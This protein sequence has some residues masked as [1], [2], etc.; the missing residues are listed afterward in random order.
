MNKELAKFYINYCLNCEID[1][2]ELFYEKS[3]VTEA[4]LKE[5]KIEEASASIKNGLG[6]RLAYKDKISYGSTSNMDKNN[7][8]SIID[9]LKN[10]YNKKRI[11]DEVSLKE[12]NHEFDYKELSLKE[13][14]DLLYNINC[15]AKKIEPKIYK[16]N[17]VLS[18]KNQNVI[19]A[20]SKGKFVKDK[21]IY[22]LLLIEIIMK[23]GKSM[24]T[25]SKRFGQ[26]SNCEFLKNIDLEKELKQLINTAKAKLN[27]VTMKGGVMPAVIGPGF[28]AVIFHE[29]VGHALEATSVGIKTSVLTGKYNKLIASDK[30]TLVDDGT[31]ENLWGTTYY[32]D[33]GNKTKRNVL[34]DSGKLTSYLIDELN[35]KKMN[36]SITG[37][38]RRENYKFIPT[39]R[40]NNTYLMPGS[41]SVSDMIKSIKYGLYA[42]TMGGGSVDPVTG[43]FNFAVDEGYIIRDGKICEIVKLVSLIG[44]TLDI[45]KQVEMVS[46]NLSFGEGFCGST[47]GYVNTTIGQPTIKVK[48]ILV[49]GK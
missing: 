42:K 12:N 3:Y 38:G 41:D 40:M 36:M 44:N 1:F 39:S 31:L 46:D 45:L 34:I 24:S 43:D 4:K 11:I 48:N 6:I 18:E 32:D 30:V 7:I 22:N 28:G 27:A 8:L 14:K 17:A 23:N 29:A 16:V 5:G 47:S 25:A 35:S 37:S 26:S 49:G 33:E 20:N 19:I 10:N 15:I 2:A 21:R 9:N 13:K